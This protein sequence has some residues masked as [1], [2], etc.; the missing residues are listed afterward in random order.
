MLSVIQ[1]MKIPIVNISADTSESQLQLELRHLVT[2]PTTWIVDAMLGTG[3]QGKLREPFAKT[4]KFSNSVPA[5]RMAIDIP[6]GLD[7]DS[8]NA[9]AHSF[10]ADVCCTFIAKKPGFNQP[11]AQ[12]ITGDICVIDIGVTP[13]RTEWKA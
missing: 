12:Q 6:T 13:D 1:Q 11:S 4:A 9:D 8:G 7:A 5:K 2:L 10:Q 3:A